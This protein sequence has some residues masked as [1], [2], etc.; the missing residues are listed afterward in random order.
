MTGWLILYFPKETNNETF[1]IT[2]DPH[3]IRTKFKVTYES[4]AIELALSVQP[5]RRR[6]RIDSPQWN[7]HRVMNSVQVC[8][9]LIE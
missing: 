2:A 9:T 7:L 1:Q 5:N 3:K 4:V 6:F 8:P